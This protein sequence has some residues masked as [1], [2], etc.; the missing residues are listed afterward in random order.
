VGDLPSTS[1]G[2][3]KKQHTVSRVVLRQFT[4]GE[5]G[6]LEEF[7][8][9]YGKSYLRRVEQVG[10]VEDFV[11]H[12]P[13]ETE[14]FWS[15]TENKV[16]R[17]IKAIGNGEDLDPSL[18]DV[19][20]DL[21]ALHVVRSRTRLEA[22]AVILERTKRQVEQELM[23]DK[24]AL[25]ERFF[26]R[27]GFYPAGPELFAE[28][29]RID[30]EFGAE[31]AI[32]DA[33]FHWR[34]MENFR[35]AQQYLAPA[36]VEVLVVAE[37]AE[38]LLISDDPAVAMKA[39]YKGLGP[40]TG[41]SWSETNTVVMPISPGV[42]L[43]LGSRAYR[44]SIDRSQVSFLNRVQLSYASERVF[45]HPGSGLRDTAKLSMAARANRPPGLGPSL[46]DL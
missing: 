7:N 36:R 15:L 40:L 46:I 24:A 43:S 23:V 31:V 30:A 8:L 18:E 14:Q 5:S 45:Y 29:A 28:Q 44:A 41:V 42:A 2:L 13:A 35:E 4:D 11:R 34:L 19:A 9:K 6:Q 17:L 16:P 3:P 32:D 25:A 21:I 20:K 10:Y 22:H 38:T 12:A 37:G 1:K 27:R 39:G 33:F 26:R